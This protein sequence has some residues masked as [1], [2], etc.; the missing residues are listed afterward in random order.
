MSAVGFTALVEVE[1]EIYATAPAN[2]GAGPLWCYGSTCIGRTGGE[3]L[4]SGLETI[5]DAQ[6]LNNTRWTL[7]R[8]GERG[9]ELLRRDDEGRTREP[10]PLVV[11]EDGR[12]FLSVNPTLTPPDTHGGPA[13]PQVLEFAARPGERPRVH[14]PAWAGH[15]EFTEHSYRSLAADRRQGELVLFNNVGYDSAHWSF[16]DRTGAW[17]ACGQLRFPYG[18]EYEE[19]VPIRVCYPEVALDRRAVHF[20]GIS[21]IVEPVKAWREY[22]R[23]LTGREWDYD[24]RRLFYT[25]TPDLAAVP[26]APWLEIASREATCGWISN[27]DLHLAADGGV[28]LLWL[29]K[30]VDVRLRERFFPDERLSVAL[31]WARVRDGRVDA[32]CRLLRWSEGEAGPVPA[33]ARFH[34]HPDGR[35]FVLATCRRDDRAE[36]RVIEVRPDGTGGSVPLALEQPLANFMT[37]TPRAGNPASECADLYGTAG[38]HTRMRYARVRIR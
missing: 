21:D 24:F 14:R 8:R 28:D 32:R 26:F 38:D 23:Q 6:P 3:V 12:A 2:N 17:S 13:D 20:L 34:A 27:L 31:E 15:P 22:K 33:W 35:L 36:M 37:A 4:V 16:L 30:S 10:A 11:Y 1:E 7:W 5:P 19:P 29:E 18:S 25:W 9:W